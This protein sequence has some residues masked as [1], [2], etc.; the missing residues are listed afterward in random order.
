MNVFNA[1]KGCFKLFRYNFAKPFYC[2]LFFKQV[3]NSFIF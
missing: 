2:H 1:P 3:V